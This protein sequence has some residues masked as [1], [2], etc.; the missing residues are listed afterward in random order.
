MKKECQINNLINIFEE[1]NKKKCYYTCL[2][3]SKLY[4]FRII[5]LSEI[6]RKTELTE[7]IKKS[8]INLLRIR[9]ATFRM[10][11][12]PRSVSNLNLIT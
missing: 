6:F 11:Y 7:F 2:N 9:I 1:F 10:F 5:E 12:V 4:I 8:V 3:L